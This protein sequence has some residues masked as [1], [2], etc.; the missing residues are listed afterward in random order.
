VWFHTGGA[1]TQPG[2]RLDALGPVSRGGD[3]H[4]QATRIA[5]VACHSPTLAPRG[6]GLA[7]PALRFMEQ[8]LTYAVQQDSRLP[9]HWRSG[10]PIGWD[11]TARDDLYAQVPSARRAAAGADPL[12]QQ[13]WFL[14]RG[15][16]AAL[17][18]DMFSG[19]PAVLS[20]DVRLPG[21]GKASHLLACRA[22][23]AALPRYRAT[24]PAVIEGSTLNTLP[25]ATKGL[26]GDRAR[27]R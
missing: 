18:L 22:V 21:L 27:D 23:R 15:G 26:C 24:L 4:E 14:V 13:F 7:Q 5:D 8:V 25:A 10:I 12:D 20:G 1:L 17:A 6:P 19:E 11:E 9:W 2:D 16:V 3:S